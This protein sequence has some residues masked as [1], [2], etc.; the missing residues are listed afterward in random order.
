M[1]TFFAGAATMLVGV[2]F[3]YAMGANKKSAQD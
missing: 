3:G 1:L 2:I